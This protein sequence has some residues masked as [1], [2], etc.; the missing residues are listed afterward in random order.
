MASSLSQTV[1]FSVLLLLSIHQ[2]C[3]KKDH[4]HF[5]FHE[6]LSGPNATV[7]VSVMAPNSTSFTRG[8]ISVID[9]MLREG[10]DDN[11]TLIGN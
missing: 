1:L 10:Q 11:S 3:A 9:D 6:I 7:L 5:Y 2:T 8:A 4:L